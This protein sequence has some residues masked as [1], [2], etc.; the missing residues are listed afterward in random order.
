MSSLSLYGLEIEEAGQGTALATALLADVRATGRVLLVAWEVPG[1][2]LT[3][4]RYHV[5]PPAREMTS[6]GIARRLTGGRA[7]PLGR[8]FVGLT[9]ALADR[10]ALLPRTASPL[11]PAQIPNRYVRGLLGALELLGVHA[12][13]PG[14]DVITV[15]GRVIASLGFEVCA[16]GAVLIEVA[17]AVGRSFA[18][19]S[20]IADAADPTGVVPTNLLLPEQ[21]TSIGEVTGR[22]PRLEELVSAIAAGYA[23]RLD[24]ETT[25][26]APVTIRSV[27]PAWLEQG[28]LAPHLDRHATMRAM[29]G[30]I[31]V[32]AACEGDVVADVRV[33]G[34]FIAPAYTVDA[35]QAALRGA[36]VDRAALR[37]RSAD[38]AGGGFILGVESPESIGDLVFEACRQ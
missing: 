16:D 9:V 5:V 36:P 1:A 37:Q 7:A 32:H 24:V 28:R 33:C 27:D 8:G 29:L 31:D 38:A 6:V 10:N 22:T 21:G 18:D 25:R 4:G 35:L 26:C 3:L 34:D 14:R 2:V 19:L 30:V 12:Y 11:S 23:A 20:H 15:D 13:Y 17:L